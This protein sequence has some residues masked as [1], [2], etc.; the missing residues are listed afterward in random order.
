MSAEYVLFDLDGTL[1]DPGMGITNSV[2]HALAHFG[3]QKTFTTEEA[4]G[5]FCNGARHAVASALKEAIGQTADAETIIS[6]AYIDE[7]LAYY[8]PYYAAHSDINYK[9][10]GK[11][12][13]CRRR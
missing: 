6:D 4:K 12:N 9:R 3:Y 2:A 8:K 13:T 7:V 11:G 1:T 10:R 5:F